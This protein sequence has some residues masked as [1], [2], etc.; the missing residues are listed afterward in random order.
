[1]VVVGVLPPYCLL[2]HLWLSSSDQG[3]GDICSP[4]RHRPGI[5][6][7]ISLDEDT[8][9]QCG[10][11]SVKDTSSPVFFLK[12]MMMRPVTTLLSLTNVMGPWLSTLCV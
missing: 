4:Q 8:R 2:F 1:M 11:A 5:R 3:P 7:S 10:N 9:A 12:M 6:A